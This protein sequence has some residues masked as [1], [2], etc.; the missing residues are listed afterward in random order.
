[1]VILG[2]G[3]GGV[4]SNVSPLMAEQYTRTTP[5][6]TE[7]RGKK[8][9]IDPKVTMQS[10]FNWFYWAINI[11]A[12]SSI[13]TTNTEKYHS[14]WLAYLLPLIVFIGAIVVLIIG[15]NRYVRKPPSGS[16]LIRAGRVIGTAIG[17]RWR[18]GRLPNHPNLL[19][20]AKEISSQ[21]DEDGKDIVA[22][23]NSNR[24]VDDLKK[25]VPQPQKPLIKVYQTML[26]S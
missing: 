18:L 7:I 25:A 5:V 1:M 17:N 9:I 21:V 4:K 13:I 2:A 10:M 23:E 24:F 14:F 19:D 8:K 6:I 26:F 20:Y 11:G 16:L 15:G 3:A 22:T 12:L